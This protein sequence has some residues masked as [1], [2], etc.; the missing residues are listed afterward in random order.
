MLTCVGRFEGINLRTGEHLQSGGLQAPES[1]LNFIV[2]NPGQNNPVALRL[3]VKR[4]AKS[5]SGYQIVAD[6][7]DEVDHDLDKAGLNDDEGG[8]QE[9]AV[10]GSTR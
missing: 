6:T 7:I 2:S 4:N 3:G 10:N 5:V 9:R 8:S 1:I